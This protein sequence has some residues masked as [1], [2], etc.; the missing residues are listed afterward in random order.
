M[1]VANRECRYDHRRCAD[2]EVQNLKGLFA[3]SVRGVVGWGR[4]SALLTGC[5]EINLEGTPEE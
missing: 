1:K 3:F 2:W 5:L 4:F